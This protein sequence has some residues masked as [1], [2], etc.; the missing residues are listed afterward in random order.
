M[1]HFEEMS[2]I[3]EPLGFKETA[4]PGIYTHVIQKGIHNRRVFDF[5]TVSIEGVV[6]K[7]F[8]DGFDSGVEYIQQEFSNVLNRQPRNIN[9]FYKR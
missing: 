7:I 2:K 8:Q 3:L 4:C 1:N 6:A 9:H 5:T